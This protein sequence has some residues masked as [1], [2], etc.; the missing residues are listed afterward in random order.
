MLSRIYAS[1]GRF[2]EAANEVASRNPTSL[3]ARVLRTAPT[4]VDAPETLPHM[5]VTSFAYLYVG[6]AD[7]F[8]ESRERQL[9]VGYSIP[10]G[11]AEL[12]DPAPA[13]AEV[14][15]TERF[16]AFVRQARLVEYWHV[17]GWP[18][19]CRPVGSNDFTCD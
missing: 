15:K 6:A 12:W 3:L 10:I 9:E 1:Q 14:R 5:D 7:R 18:E 16:K 8:L 19:F 13:Y 11:Y 4:K 2:S 17:K